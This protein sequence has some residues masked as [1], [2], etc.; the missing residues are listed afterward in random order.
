M[1]ANQYYILFSLSI[2]ILLIIYYLYYSMNNK[3]IY[4]IAVFTGDI[5]G[6]VKLK[7]MVVQE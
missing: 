5:K 7:H 2:I 4:A 6:Y 1:K 3:P